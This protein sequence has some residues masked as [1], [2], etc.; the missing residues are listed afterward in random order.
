MTNSIGRNLLNN[1]FIHIH[2]EYRKRQVIFIKHFE[3]RLS[4]I[5]Y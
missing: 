4:R 2:D 1:L 3:E 5:K